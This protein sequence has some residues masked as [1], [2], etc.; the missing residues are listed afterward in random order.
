MLSPT[1]NAQEADAIR[2]HQWCR[3]R[4]LFE[5]HEPL[6]EQIR[7]AQT[8]QIQLQRPREYSG[9]L[10]SPG[11]GVWKGATSP[12]AKDC[13]LISTMPLYFEQVHSPFR[14]E[15]PK[16]IYYEVKILKFGG[17]RSTNEDEHALAMGFCAVP[18]PTWRMPGWERGSLAVH[19][20]D[21]RRYVSDTDGG[22]DFTHP[23]RAGETV[24]LGI[25][26]GLPDSQPNFVPTPS[27]GQPLKGRVFLTRNGVDA[28]DW[29]IQEEMD[30]ESEFGTLGVDGKYDLYAAIGIFGQVEFEVKFQPKD[31]LWN[32]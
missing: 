25:H 16:T 31:W 10:T 17:H 26:F 11:P 24:G 8:G 2:A 15:R 3:Q 13:V 29:N 7:P 5:P 12:G 4:P 27:K 20:D 21:G 23:F 9:S 19:S 6:P 14:T 32:P 1:G 18:Y 28:G 30:A 22:V